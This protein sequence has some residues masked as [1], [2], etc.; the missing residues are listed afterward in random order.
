MKKVLAT[1]VALLMAGSIATAAE[2]ED[3]S[4]VSIKGNARARV[5][6][7]DKYDFGNSDNDANWTM[8]SRVRFDVTGTAAGGAYIKGRIRLIEQKFN[9]EADISENNNIYADKAYIGVPFTDE[10]TLEAG[11]YRVTYGNGFMY[12]DIGLAG[13]RGIYQNEQI[14]VV[15]FFEVESE[16]Q[17]SDIAK[18]VEEDNDSVRF[19]AAVQGTMDAWTGGI[20]AAYQTDDRVES[21]IDDSGAVVATGN[22]ENDGFFGSVFVKG[23]M[24]AFGVEG[25]FAYAEEGITDFTGVDDGYGGYLRGSWTMDAL[26]LALDL[27]FT[28]DGYKPDPFYGFVMIGGEEPI[29]AQAIGEN[30]DW[31]WAG[32]RAS[33]AVTEALSLTGNLV[34]A[35]ID[36]NDDLGITDPR[37][38]NMYELSGV[39]KYAV[40]QGCTF[41]WY[42]GY[43][44]PDFDGRLDAVGVEDDGAFGTY[45]KFDVKF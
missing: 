20:L 38:A 40:S 1:G 41:S 16:G 14:L 34:Y 11:K 22:G 30:S 35:D 7:K 36:G 42:A 43:L 28:K 3:K 4:G 32:L 13:V 18:D 5:I 37:L 23:T 8:D 39:L 31:M 6:Y 26:S 12:D 27:G 45:A 44:T 17:V 10:F 33:Y 15:P 24:G 29:G 25:E 2:M 19:G 21:Y 9:G